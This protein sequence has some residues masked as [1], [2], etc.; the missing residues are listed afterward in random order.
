MNS[1][2]NR[3]AI[4]LLVE[5]EV[6]VRWA[7]AATLREAGFEVL[8]VESAA[9]ALPILEGRGDVTVVFTDINMP[10]AMNGQALAY[11]VDR[12]WPSIRLLVTSG[13]FRTHAPLL[14][15]GSRFL[16]KPYSDMDLIAGVNALAAT[17]APARSSIG[18]LES[19]SFEMASLVPARWVSR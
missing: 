15:V 19:R 9:D 13:A 7:A 8:D 5:D 6:L 16:A 12:R 14:P 1:S 10:G 11:E 2:R 3:R 4:V 17:T 18:R